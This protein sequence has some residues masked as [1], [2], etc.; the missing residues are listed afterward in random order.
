MSSVYY[1]LRYL[2]W[3]KVCTLAMTDDALMLV[4]RAGALGGLC[5][6]KSTPLGVSLEFKDAKEAVLS[7]GP[8]EMHTLVITEEAMKA[9]LMA[10]LRQMANNPA[11][12][13]MLDKIESTFEFMAQRAKEIREQRESYEE[14]YEDEEEEVVVMRA[15]DEDPED[16]EDPE[17]D[18]G[19][20]PYGRGRGRGR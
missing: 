7:H 15:G 8:T 10:G 2:W 17:D 3:Q 16:P 18:E 11:V 6:Q 4:L 5:S 19:E 13:K 14:G 12:Q 9:K 1:D 20:G